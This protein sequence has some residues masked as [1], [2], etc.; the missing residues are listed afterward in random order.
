MKTKRLAVGHREL[1][2]LAE[3]ARERA[4]APYSGFR[5]GAAVLTSRGKV[6]TGSNIENASYGLTLCAERVA[7]SKAVSEG[8]SRIIAIAVVSDGRQPAAPCGACRQVLH[9]FGAGMPVILANLK[10]GVVMEDLS[11]LLPQAFGRSNSK[12]A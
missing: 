3:K 5:V 9:E 11:H 6:Y 8:D 1:I 12:K 10:G 7:V 2:R 4:Y